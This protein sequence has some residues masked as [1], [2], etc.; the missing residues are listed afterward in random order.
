MGYLQKIVGKCRVMFAAQ[1]T[2]NKVRLALIAVMQLALVVAFVLAVVDY[3]WLTAFICIIALG[4][5]WLPAWLARSFRVHFPI[6]FQLLLNL[7]IY[8]S[9]FLGE[10][11]G[12]YT[13][14]WWWDIV[15]HTGSGIALGFIGFLILYSLYQTRQI[16]ISPFLLALF[17]FC[18]ALSLGALWEI[19]EFAMDSWFGF[20]M[21]KSG[22]VDTM[23][24]LIVD[25]IGALIVAISGYFYIKH[26]RQDGGL[27]DRYIQLYFAKNK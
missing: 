11:R 24:D 27:F 4:I 15:L 18:F 25:A 1:T 6:E 23:W 5:V 17:S 16:V 21:Q 12:Y 7:F 20:N 9:I 22:L 19:F 13:R 8:S 26:N 14:F 10:I 2:G 3:A